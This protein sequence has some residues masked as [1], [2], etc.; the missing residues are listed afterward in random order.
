MENYD[1]DKLL[2]M[3]RKDQPEALGHFFLKYYKSLYRTVV[4]IVRD[5][6]DAKDIL[7]ELFYNLWIK[8]CSLN[9]KGSIS[10]YLFRSAINRSLNY[11]RDNQK[12]EKAF[13]NT[14]ITHES[15]S[16]DETPLKSVELKE[17]KIMV[18][19]QIWILPEK[20]KICFMLSRY[21][22]MSNKEI[23]ATLGVTEKAVEKNITKALKILKKSMAN[24]FTI[25][26]ALIVMTSFFINFNPFKA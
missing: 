1:D 21:I 6:D 23:A 10:A 13:S 2:E 14:S 25:L 12:F 24:Y 9:F 22:N 19:G 20:P 8:R 11:L 15:S 26:L 5:Q 18:R 17:L 3:L 16:L 7:Q 4:H